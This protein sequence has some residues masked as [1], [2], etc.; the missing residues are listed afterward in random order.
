MSAGCHDGSAFGEN[1]AVRAA[2]L[3]R[4]ALRDGALAAFRDG[5]GFLDGAA[6]LDGAL[7]GGAALRDGAAVV[8]V[9]SPCTGA[10]AV[11]S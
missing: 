7:H 8:R 10:S 5:A 1:R 9:S 2:L 6:L 11:R 3:G 4:D